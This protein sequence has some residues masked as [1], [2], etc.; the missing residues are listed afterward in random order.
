M[1]FGL[2]FKKRYLVLIPIVLSA[3]VAYRVLQF[4]PLEQE[5]VKKVKVNNL[6][7]LYITEAS[8][9]ATTGFSYR[10]YLYDAK[11]SDADFVNHADH[12]TPFMIT[13]DNEAT[14]IV[15]E[16][17]VYLHVHGDVYSFHNTSYLA[18]VYLDASPN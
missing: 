11:K 18:R 13:T 6:T 4:S 14:V 5:I 9:G 1:R 2:A 15:K 17:K 12:E 10:Y 8:A 3:F 7:N 16:D